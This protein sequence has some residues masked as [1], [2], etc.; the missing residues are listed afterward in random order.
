MICKAM[1]IINPVKWEPTECHGIFA[2]YTYNRGLT[3]RI[4]KPRRKTEIK[5]NYQVKTSK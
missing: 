3:S 5:R 2:G 4:Q 1:A